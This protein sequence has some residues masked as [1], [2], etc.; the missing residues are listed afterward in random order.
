[1]ST[2]SLLLSNHLILCCPFLLLP[3]IFPRIRVFSNE[4]DL[5]I[6]WPNYWSFSFSNSSSNEYSGF[7]FFRID[8]F[9]FL[10]VQDSPKSLLQH[11]S[12][13]A[14]ILW[15]SAFLMVQLSQLTYDPAIPLLGIYPK[16]NM[17]QRN[18]CIALFIAVLFTITVICLQCRRLGFHL[19]VGKI[20]W[21][22]ERLPTPVFWPG[23]FHELYTTWSHKEMGMTEQLSLHLQ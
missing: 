7:I 2:E 17:I 9:D 11:H 19:W 10:A 4:S 22:R 12:S 1:M 23:E 8:W 5:P 6:R 18:V 15:C 3:S 20:L 16:K 21:R 14:S 13:N